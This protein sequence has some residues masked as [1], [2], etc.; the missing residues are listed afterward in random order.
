MK[1][2]I[3]IYTLAFFMLAGCT[4]KLDFTA[5]VTPVTPT[6]GTA[7]L[8]ISEVSTAINTDKNGGGKRNHYVELYNATTSSIDLS[9]YAIGYQATDSSN[10]NSI[11]WSF[12]DT[13]VFKQLSGSLAAST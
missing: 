12:P 10:L 3:L 6:G 1:K 4:S 7:D 8:I 11:P 9:N 5:P 13:T 2:N